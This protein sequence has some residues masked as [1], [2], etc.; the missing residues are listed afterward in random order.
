MIESQPI[1]NSSL[2]KTTGP[3]EIDSSLKESAQGEESLRSDAQDLDA[4][5]LDS[6]AMDSLALAKSCA[7]ILDSKKLLDI[8]V[9]DVRRTLQIS[10]YFVLASGLNPRQL[11][12]ACNLM[13][14]ELTSCRVKRYGIEGYVEGNWILLDFETVVVHLFLEENR[15]YYDLELLWGDSPLVKWAE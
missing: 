14:K 12:A 2:D 8:T 10:D 7:R 15:R 1:W 3:S 11:K 4:Q 9:F 5:D 13:A 6:L